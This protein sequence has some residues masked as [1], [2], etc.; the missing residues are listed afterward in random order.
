MT[1][2]SIVQQQQSPASALQCLTLKLQQLTNSL[3]LSSI[4]SFNLSPSGDASNLIAQVKTALTSLEVELLHQQAITQGVYDFFPTP[5]PL[6]ERM[7]KLAQI[8]PGMKVLEPQAGSGHVCREVRKLGVEP[9]CFEIS[10][11]LRRGLLLQRF[12]VIGEDFL[13][14]TPSAIYDLILANPPLSRNGVARHTL[15][16]L[17]WLRP[18]GRLVTVA[19]H[20][21]LRPSATDRAF[22]QWLQG[23]DAHFYDCGQAFQHGDR[24]CNTPIQLIV[25][26]KPC[27]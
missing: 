5:Q 16:A 22:F 10:P 24:P 15:R 2:I 9:D 19:H 27:W 21:Q 7:L 14:S 23:F 13:A 3:E 25:I 1:S 20:Y 6:I 8:E 17:D 26:E 4:D 12:N 11:L 18:G